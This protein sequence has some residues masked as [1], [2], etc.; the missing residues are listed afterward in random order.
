[1]LRFYQRRAWPPKLAVIWCSSLEDAKAGALVIDVPAG[2]TIWFKPQLSGPVII[3]YEAIMVKAGGPHDRV[4][5]LN[6]F[7]MATDARSPGDLFATGRSGKFEDYNQLRTYYVGQGG[8]GNTTTRFRRYVGSADQRPLLPEHDLRSPQF[9]L[10][11]NVSQVIQLVAW[12]SRIQYWRNGK[13]VFDFVDESPPTVTSHSGR[14]I[15]TWRF[16][17]FG[18][19][20]PCGNDGS[21]FSSRDSS[22]M[23]SKATDVHTYIEDVALERRVTIEKLRKICRKSEPC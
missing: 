21:E 13:L 11:P 17:I 10:K 20:G 15:A 8:N 16:A 19:I 2:A 6:C 14:R 12:G 1:M 22:A 3:Q 18:S 9:L 23:A 4:S 7:W 5:D